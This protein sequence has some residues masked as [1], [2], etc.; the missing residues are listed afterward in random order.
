MP[1]RK[2]PPPG[3]PDLTLSRAGDLAEVLVPG[4]VCSRCDGERRGEQPLFFVGPEETHNGIVSRPSRC[5]RQHL[6][7][8]VIYWPDP[9][10][11]ERPKGAS[12]LLTHS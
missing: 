5:L 1:R 12:D 8:V 6:N 9:R 10:G 2:K 7:Y 4:A 11:S 3:P